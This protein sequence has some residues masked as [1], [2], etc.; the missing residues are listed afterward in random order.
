MKWNSRVFAVMLAI[1]LIT[2]AP[3]MA[4]AGY[5][6]IKGVAKDQAGQP[7]VGGTIDLIGKETGAKYH[8]KTDKKGEYFSI[9]VQPGIYKA[10]LKDSAGNV[11][12][13][14]DGVQV[15]LA[16]EDSLNVVDFDLAKE[17]SDALNNPSSLTPEQKKQM[18]EYKKKN[19]QVAQENQKITGL[20]EL[21]KQA[22]AAL[23]GGN[24]DQAIT[25]MAQATQQDATKD[26]LWA[27]LADAHLAAAKKAPTPADR[28][29]HYTEAVTAYKKAIDLATAGQST[30]NPKV[31][32]GYYNNYA[33]SLAKTGQAQPAV[34]AW[35]KAAQSD[36]P[37]AATYYFNEGATLTNTGKSEEAVKAFDK[38]LQ[39]DPNR[40]EAYYYKGVNLLAKATTEGSK[41]IAP[42]GTAEAFNKY[43]EVAPDGPNAANAKMMLETIGAKVET[44]YK[45]AKTPPKK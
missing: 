44:S 9:G 41:M 14:S 5:A 22:R 40:A 39:S 6:K 32:A 13:T 4:Q 27:T 23:A 8:F 18:E 30:I 25:L 38:A 21:L 20:N 31:L 29:P 11:L 45:K 28:A 33:D 15:R 43:L 19:E 35:E 36:P 34:E 12:W 1:V 42:P 3:A 24:P 2:A 26:L 7:I 10:I 37:S 17:K 16:V